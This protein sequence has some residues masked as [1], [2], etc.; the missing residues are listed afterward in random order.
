[1]NLSGYA[2][3]MIRVITALSVVVIAAGAI[4]YRSF[5]VMP[6]AV[7]VALS[8]A[9]NGIK[10]IL[11]ENSIKKL[12]DM[13]DKRAYNYFRVQYL[14]RY[15]LTGAVFVVAAFSPFISIWGAGAGII[16]FQIAAYSLKSYTKD[17]EGQQNPRVNENES[18][19]V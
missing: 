17:L 1:M 5:S 11:I 19:S 9:L 13:D 7:G 12:V 2:K 10:V 4:Y 6:F 16:I 3:R 8:S 15:L 18:S 14:V